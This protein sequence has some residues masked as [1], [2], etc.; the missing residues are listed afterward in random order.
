[1]HRVY[2]NVNW[3]LIELPS[4][5]R[6]LGVTEDTRNGPVV[7]WP[8]PL[9]LTTL[10]PLERVCLCPVRR[11]NPFL[12]LMDG[13]SILTNNDSVL[14]LAQIVPRFLEYSDDGVTLRGHYGKRLFAQIPRAIR[15]L[16]ENPE[17]RRVTLSI[18]N[19]MD[20]L[21]VQSKD[22]PCNV[23]V[24]LRIVKGA[25]DL[26]VFNRSNDVFWG[27]LGANIVQFSFLQE[28][29]ANVLGVP[30]GHLHQV[31]TNAHI[32]TGFG[33]GK[34]GMKFT[35]PEGDYPPTRVLNVTGLRDELGVIW[36]RLTAELPLPIA[37]NPF[38][39]DIVL[40]M[41]NAWRTKDPQW[42]KGPWDWHVAGRM[43]LDKGEST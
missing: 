6:A 32:Y 13:L 35:R 34:G 8:D 12:F 40:P 4:E 30:V 1:M 2:R 25:L 21:A 36:D 19:W 31:S 17:S 14:P 22:I 23:H 26:T 15:E 10:N 41:L 43:Y 9:I 27:M 29:I 7:S 11:C 38:L 28:Y 37:A 42:I 20:D 18:W 24:N 3:A 33:P 39:A 16:Q 5:I